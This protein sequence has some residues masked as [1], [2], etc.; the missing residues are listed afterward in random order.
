MKEMIL[1]QNY[2]LNLNQFKYFIYCV[3]IQR[4][5]PNTELTHEK[6][7]KINKSLFRD[8]GRTLKSVFGDFQGFLVSSLSKKTP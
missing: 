3:Q 5:E 8:I 4:Y 2:M 6:M 7:P 1:V